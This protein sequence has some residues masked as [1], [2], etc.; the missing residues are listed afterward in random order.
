MVYRIPCQDC[1]TSYI[2]ETGRSLKKRIAE[3]KCAVKDV[4]AWDNQH[5][6]DWDAAEIIERELHLLKRSARSHLDTEDHHKLELGLRSSSE[7]VLGTV[8]PLRLPTT[9]IPFTSTSI[10]IFYLISS[11]A[12]PTFSTIYAGRAFAHV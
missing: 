6:P 4:H 7:R 5:R 11:S 10:S 9:F 3:H 2:G 8:H 12:P 1:E